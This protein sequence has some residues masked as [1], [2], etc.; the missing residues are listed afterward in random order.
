MCSSNALLPPYLGSSAL[1][2]MRCFLP[3]QQRQMRKGESRTFSSHY[4]SAGTPQKGHR[5][6]KWL[7]RPCMHCHQLSQLLYKAASGC[8]TSGASEVAWIFFMEKALCKSKAWTCWSW[9][10]MLG[11]LQVQLQT[12][13][14]S[15][16]ALGR[17][18]SSSREH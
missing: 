5:T 16:Q 2:K 14:S 11:M 8:A 13:F 12:C 17:W 7:P 4:V 1:T 3:K 9:Q 10:D 6:A 15:D 18:F